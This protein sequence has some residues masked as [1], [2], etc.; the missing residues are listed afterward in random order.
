MPDVMAL[1]ALSVVP[2]SLL[3]LFLVS[4]VG[5]S[6]AGCEDKSK[7]ESS[8]A[9][10]DDKKEKKKKK[11]KK[12]KN[13][14]QE[15]KGETSAKP[16]KIEEAVAPAKIE[17][18]PP[19]SIDDASKQKAK[20]FVG[21]ITYG[22]FPYELIRDKANA[23]AFVHLAATWPDADVVTAALHAMYSSF[24][25]YEKST[26]R[27]VAD[28][29]YARAVLMKI[30]DP[31]GKVQ[32]AALKAAEH[33]VA[34]DTPHPKVVMALVDLA[35]HHAKP[36]GRHAAIETLGRVSD[37][38]K[39]DAWLAPIIKALDATEPWL[40]SEALYQ[41]KYKMYDVKDK[42]VMKAK[43]E[44]LLKHADPGVRGYAAEAL[45]R[46]AGFDRT[47]QAD[48]ATL[49]VPLLDDPNPFTKSAACEA[50]A[51]LREKK[52][53]HKIIT[54]VEDTTANTYDIKGWTQL[55]G[56]DGYQH[57]DGSAWSTVGDAALSSIRMFSHETST[58]FEYKID[59]KTKEA[60]LK[61]AA[62]DAKTW[63]ATVKGEL[64]PTT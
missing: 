57:H 18:E 61:K 51:Y 27:V 44:P 19:A 9:E 21:K 32:H 48:Y 8:E 26:D 24:T 54:M 45:A 50:M 62:A 43:L 56:T 63:Y 53:F 31:N 37:L 3:A 58:K 59:Y 55:D 25:S 12:K 14:D 30:Q 35:A 49:I 13:G 36:E 38:T 1:M 15:A 2:R 41:L 29:D 42:A 60:D 64:G 40:V 4:A 20:E 22:R 6:V 47:V 23:K 46:L 33:S 52:A 7:D 28:E 5:L 11:S 17:V 34:L 39:N 10:D 16:E